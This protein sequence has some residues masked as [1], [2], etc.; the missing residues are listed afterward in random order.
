MR[1]LIP[2]A[3]VGFQ[4][5]GQVVASNLLGFKELPTTVLTSVYSG[6]ATDRRVMAGFKANPKRNRRVAAVV[7]LAL[8]AISG[9]WLMKDKRAGMAVILWIAT[10]LKFFI[11]GCWL[12]WRKESL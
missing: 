5:G 11:A 8:G 2:I 4:A 1:V 3:L 7:L 9:G 12:F 10:G 6:L